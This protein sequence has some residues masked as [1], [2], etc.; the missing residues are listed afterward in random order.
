MKIK[1]LFS[2]FRDSKEKDET[3]AELKRAMQLRTTLLDNSQKSVK[4]LLERIELI[5][6]DYR[7]N[8]GRWEKIK[9]LSN[10]HRQSGNTTWIL[11][12]AVNNPSCVIVVGNAMQKNQM[13]K[14]LNKMIKPDWVKDPDKV[15]PLVVYLGEDMSGHN[16][17]LIFDN[18][19]LC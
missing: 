5:L 10:T 1:E 4:T 15:Y 14:Q 12:A 9:N 19:V 8:L 13:E 11:E 7:E 6:M 16:R 2:A 18:S 3:I 17:P